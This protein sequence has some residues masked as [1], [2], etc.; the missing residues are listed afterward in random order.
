MSGQ[1]IKAHDVDALAAPLR[2]VVELALAEAGRLGA[3]SAEAD[4]SL[5]QGL[6]VNARLGDVETIEHNR[7]K[8]LSV[9][10]YFGQRS[11][12]ATTSDMSEAAVAATVKAACDIAR[13]T[14][15]DDCGGLADAAEMAREFPELDLWHPWGPTAE[16]ALTMAIECEDAARATSP[17]ITNSEGATVNSH[18]GIG[19]YANTHGFRGTRYGTRHSLSCAVI[20]SD[21]QGMERDYWY[22]IVRDRRAL[23]AARE[24]GEIAAR[25]SLQRL[26]ARQLGTRQAPVIFEAPVASSLLSHF[27]SAVNGGNLYRRSSFLIDHLGKQVFPAHVTLAE[28]P[29]APGR[30]ASANFDSE[31]VATRERDIVHAGILEG[32]VLNSYAARKLGLRTTGNAGGVHNLEISHGD[33]G[34]D[35][36]LRQVGRGLLVTELIGF[37]VNTVTG[38]YSRGAAG[39]WIENGEIAYPVSEI[40]I[41]GNLRDMFLAVEAVG[42]DT[43]Q[44][45]PICTGSIVIG[46]M[47]IAGE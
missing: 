20:A 47:T 4:A 44:R 16:E 5:S 9:S 26:G 7:D 22:S 38:D 40:T 1:V 28:R 45:G 42:N 21:E 35:E 17:R 27:V 12:A 41:A 39:F 36:L 33:Q 10:V 3:S 34:L 29:H 13:L 11:G 24:V 6:S 30:L 32:Y 37:G 15:E 2:D 8:S 43:L 31:G 23:Q 14:A 18:E 46:N 19:I 25:R